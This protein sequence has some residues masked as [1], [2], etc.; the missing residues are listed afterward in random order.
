MPILGPFS[1]NQPAETG[2]G[3]TGGALFTGNQ[4]REA[5][6]TSSP[7]YAAAFLT[8]R[9]RMIVLGASLAKK[10]RK[11]EWTRE[12]RRSRG[13][14]RAEK[15]GEMVFRDETAGRLGAVHQGFA[16]TSA[17]EKFSRRRANFRWSFT[18]GPSWNSLCLGRR[19][20]HIESGRAVDVGIGIGFEFD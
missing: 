8:G 13:I 2:S 15:K 11:I 6:P 12:R 18:Q 10:K 9:K 17:S 4:A 19:S 14:E 20:C 3:L 16:A 7:H 5:P 1:S